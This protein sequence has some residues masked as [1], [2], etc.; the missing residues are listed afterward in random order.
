MAA[1]RASNLWLAL[2]AVVMSTFLWFL[3][4]G[5]AEIERGYDIP[6]VFQD[7]PD[8]L[9]ITD[10]S[11]DVVNVQ[12]QG[13]RAAHRQF[14]ASRTEYPIA[15]AGGKPGPAVYEVDVS[16]IE[17]PRGSRI[18]SRSPAAIEVKFERRGRK[19]VEIR[20]DLEGEPAEGYA[21]GEVEVD[22]PRVWLA[23]ARSAV[24]RLSEVVTETIDVSGVTGPI[25]RQARLSLG[26]EHVWMEENQPVTVRVHVEPLVP[27]VEDSA[28]EEAKE[29]TG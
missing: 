24:L 4:H 29:Q 11:A 23:G 17:L 21:L 7:I 16:R 10:Q 6:V 13:T 26:S 18:V 28:G 19:S 8:R 12:L 2:L 9:V 3:A 1:S 20:P 22:P 14:F 27:P 15:V 25:E 5:Q